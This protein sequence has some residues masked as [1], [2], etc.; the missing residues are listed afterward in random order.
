[1]IEDV[2]LLALGAALLY[3][4]GDFLVGGASSL[5][6]ALGVKPM[7]VGLTVVSLGTSS[8]EAFSSIMAAIQGSSDVAIGNIVGSNIANIGLILGA[9]ALVYPILTKARFIRREVPFMIGVAVLLTII[10]AT[11]LVPRWLGVILLLLNI[12]YLYMLTRSGEE[13]NVEEEFRHEYERGN[14]R[15]TWQSLLILLAGLVLLALGARFLV[16]GAL[17]LARNLGISELVIGLTM[18]AIGT[19]LPELFTCVIAALRKEP[20]IALG[21]VVGSNILNVLFVLGLTSV[22]QPVAVGDA[23]GLLVDALIALALSV[24]LIPFLLTGLRL[25]RREGAVLL[26]AYAGYLAYLFL[27][28]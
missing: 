9:S 11:G 7:I 17:D 8:P 6:R 4:G 19:S 26:I 18:V 13:P 27:A 14:A 15:P 23:Q 3:F 21:N 5:A 20:D 10:A 1:M 2:F 12:P 28:R 16:S 25:A 24:L 22:I